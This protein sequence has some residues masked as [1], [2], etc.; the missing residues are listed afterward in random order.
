MARKLVE[1]VKNAV[2]GKNSPV[3][4]TVRYVRKDWR[5]TAGKIRRRYINYDAVVGITG[6]AGKS[7][8][9]RLVGAILQTQAPTRTAFGVNTYLGIVKRFT[10]AR[11]GEKYW[12]QELSGHE[13]TDLLK[14]IR[15][16]RPT[17]GIVTTIGLDHIST[18]RNQDEIADVKAQLVE[19]LD[20]GHIAILNADDERIIAMAT[21]T[22]ARVLSYGTSE[23]ADVRMVSAQS[24]LP[25]RLSLTVKAGE[26]TIDIQTQFPGDRWITCILAAIACGHAMG[27]PLDACAKAI[28]GVEPEIYKDSV[29]EKNGVTVVLDTFKAPNW[30]IPTSMEIVKAAASAHKIAVIGTISDYQGTARTRYRRA[31]EAALDAADE[32]IFYGPQ[33]DRI[34]RL[35]PQHPGRLFA[36]TEFEDLRSHLES[37]LRRGSMLYIKAS[38]ADHLERIWHAFDSPISCGLTKCKQLYTCIECKRLRAK[39]KPAMITLEAPQ[40][41][42]M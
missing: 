42:A 24:G 32:V 7:T 30:S 36:I 17:I 1:S 8:T 39:R 40:A 21:R 29:H 22:K 11:R 23:S 9:A 15:F 3:R 41:R 31:A 16:V 2:A 10:K 27:V 14:Q 13:R 19:L 37:R 25:R 20:P 4:K 18:H 38:G 28:S 35:L 34:R 33:S 12:V 6:S 5:R 26:Q